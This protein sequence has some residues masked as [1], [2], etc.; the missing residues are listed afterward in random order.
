MSRDIHLA[1]SREAKESKERN[2]HEVRI[3]VIFGGRKIGLCLELSMERA[4]EKFVLFVT[5]G[6][7]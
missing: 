3:V 7:D 2:S 5:P 6:N 4:F 1:D